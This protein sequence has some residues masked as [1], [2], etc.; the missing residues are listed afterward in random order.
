MVPKIIHTLINFAEG[1]NCYGLF[2]WDEIVIITINIQCFFICLLVQLCQF[3]ILKWWVW[4]SNNSTI[5]SSSTSWNHASLARI[6]ILIWTGETSTPSKL[7]TVL[8]CKFFYQPFII[9]AD[10]TF[11]DSPTIFTQSST[12]NAYQNPCTVS[13]HSHQFLILIFLVYSL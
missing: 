12:S 1:F 13:S 7:W 4:D 2:L 5:S 10:S 3:L 8:G 11:Q 9:L 6:A